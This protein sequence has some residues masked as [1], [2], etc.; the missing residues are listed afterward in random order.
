M[1]FLFLDHLLV[2]L[3][4][5]LYP[6]SKQLVLIFEFFV[7][8]L[9]GL[10][11]FDLFIQLFEFLLEFVE[12]ALAYVGAPNLGNLAVFLLFS[13]CLF[14]EQLYLVLELQHLELEVPLPFVFDG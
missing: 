3:P 11:W 5:V 2:S 7:L 12:L 9:L 6:V 1:V 14:L 13:L 8:L 10:D 4:Q